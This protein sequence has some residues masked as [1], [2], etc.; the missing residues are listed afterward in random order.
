MFSHGQ[1]KLYIFEL[2]IEKIACFQ[3]PLAFAPLGSNCAL[4]SYNP[5]IPLKVNGYLPLK[6][7]LGPASKIS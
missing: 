6:P 2:K 5:K 7:G 4:H 1:D 3:I